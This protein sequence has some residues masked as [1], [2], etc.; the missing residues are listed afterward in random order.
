MLGCLSFDS[1]RTADSREKQVLKDPEPAAI[2]ELDGDWL[3]DAGFGSKEAGFQ[4][5]CRGHVRHG[6]AGRIAL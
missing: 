6:F 5:L 2:I 1:I 4:S 3:G